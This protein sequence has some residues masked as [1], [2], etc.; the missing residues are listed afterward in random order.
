MLTA[1]PFQIESSVPFSPEETVAHTLFRKGKGK[2]TFVTLMACKNATLDGHIEQWQSLH[3]DPTHLSCI[4]QALHRYA[5]HFFPKISSMA[6]FHVGSEHCTYLVI[7][8]GRLILSGHI[9]LGS[10]R[11]SQALKEDDPSLAGDFLDDIDIS[12][13]RTPRLYRI[14]Q[15]FKQEIARVKTFLERKGFAALPTLLCGE[16]PA[17]IAAILETQFETCLTSDAK[18]FVPLQPYA[19]SLGL[20]L[21]AHYQDKYSVQFRQDKKA[22]KR[23]RYRFKK[24]LTTYV[25]LSI[26][27]TLLF[28]TMKSFGLSAKRR[29]LEKK[30]SS[31]LNKEVS[32]N[33]GISALETA[34]KK[35]RSSNPLPLAP[36]VSDVLQWVGTHPL[37]KKGKGGTPLEITRVQYKLERYPKLG[38]K[39]VPYLAKVELEIFSTSPTAARDFHNALLKGDHL[40][41]EKKEIV[42]KT[43]HNA[44]FTK[45]YLKNSRP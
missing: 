7:K 40:V 23:W 10:S 37:L 32:L 12:A 19:I 26:I 5:S 6:L 34:A 15:Q 25:S 30:L 39:K 8:E 3:A 35:N 43:S 1:L 20:A 28:G 2:E 29:S 36:K 38:E 13:G 31:V 14:E 16:I 42:W 41:D 45:F 22:S 33:E 21:D 44:Y 9:C 11:F 18:E 4:P 17:P 24:M 27:F